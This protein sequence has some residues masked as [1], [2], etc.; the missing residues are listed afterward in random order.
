M[1]QKQIVTTLYLR[2]G[3]HTTAAKISESPMSKLGTQPGG[4]GSKSSNI[5]GT[6]LVLIFDDLIGRER[7]A[8]VAT[9]FMAFERYREG[10]ERR[11]EGRGE[12]GMKEN[13]KGWSF[14]LS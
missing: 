6:F 10:E 1:A 14:V 11:G 2:S 5:Y 9:A 3:K 4:F 13:L 7:T 12:R 8:A